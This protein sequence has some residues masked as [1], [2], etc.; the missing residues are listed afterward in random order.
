MSVLVG[1]DLVTEIASTLFSFQERAHVK[2]LWKTDKSVELL[3][4]ACLSGEDNTVE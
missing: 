4:V 2:L 3:L 1:S